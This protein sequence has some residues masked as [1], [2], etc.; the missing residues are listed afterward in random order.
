MDISPED[1]IKR[2]KEGK[3]YSPERAKLAGEHFFGNGNLNALREMALRYTA[4]KVDHLLQSYKQENR[5][6]E[7]WKTGERLLVAVSHSPYSESLI[8]WTRRMAYNLGATWIAVN[9]DTSKQLSA[10]QMSL[11]K[12]ITLAREL[13]AEIVITRDDDVTDGILRIARQRNITQIV[14]GKPGSG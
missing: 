7:P 6:L 10:D 5:I 14:A 1:Q 4:E 8:R 3:I 9:V 12:N 13:G 11:Q 2:L